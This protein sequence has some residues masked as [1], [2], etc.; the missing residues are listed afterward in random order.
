MQLITSTQQL[1]LAYELSPSPLCRWWTAHVEDLSLCELLC[2]PL[3]RVSPPL[4]PL[5]ASTC[6]PQVVDRNVENLSGGELQRFAIA[7]VAAQEGEAGT[8][9]CQVTRWWQRR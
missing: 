3:S 1:L 9:A 2:Q 7:V 4:S 6:F 8:T 5:L